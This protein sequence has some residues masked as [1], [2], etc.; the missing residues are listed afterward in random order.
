MRTPFDKT[1][2]KE[3]F[4]RGAEGDEAREAGHNGLKAAV[5][6]PSLSAINEKGL[7]A[8]VALFCLLKLPAAKLLISTSTTGK[9]TV[10][11]YLNYQLPL[12]LVIRQG[13]VKVSRVPSWNLQ[14]NSRDC[15]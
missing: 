14:P 10:A 12:E 7:P 6:N 11:D 4:G 3:R 1:R 15:H 5:I 13:Q 9:S 8:R 2:P